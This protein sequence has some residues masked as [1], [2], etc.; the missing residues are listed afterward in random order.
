MLLYTGE[1]SQDGL[2]VELLCEV[3]KKR[4]AW[5][6]RSEASELGAWLTEP[7]LCFDHDTFTQSLPRALSPK[8]GEVICVSNEQ[9]CLRSVIWIDDKSGGVVGASVKPYVLEC[10]SS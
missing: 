1:V 3:C 2:R 5:L 10:L 4:V 8:P 6:T 7:V 9:R